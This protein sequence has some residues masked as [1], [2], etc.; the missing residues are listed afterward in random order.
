MYQDS[1]GGHH[2]AA[3]RDSENAY[4][5]R[6][7]SGVE[8]E[9]GAAISSGCRLYKL[10]GLWFGDG[11]AF[12]SQRLNVEVNGLYDQRVYLIAGISHGNASRQIKY[13]SAVAGGALFDD[14]GIAHAS[15]LEHARC[16]QRLWDR[17]STLTHI[18]D[19]H[20]DCASE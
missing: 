14:D 4:P 3:I 9:A 6:P 15:H 13:L 2:C 5:S 11:E 16:G 19:V 7:A 12:F 10:I 18:V 17:L 8:G 1:K 20:S